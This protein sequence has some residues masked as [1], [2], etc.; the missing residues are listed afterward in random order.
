MSKTD[1]Y[2]A[3]LTVCI[4]DLY[5]AEVMLA[6][7][8]PDVARHANDPELAGLLERVQHEANVA[9]AALA[10][11]GRHKGGAENLWMKGICKDAVRDTGSIVLGPL[12]DA[13]IVGAIRKAKAAQIVSYDTAIAVAAVLGKKDIQANL[14]DIRGRAVA[15]DE[16]LSAHLPAAQPGSDAL[17]KSAQTSS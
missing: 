9:G 1:S 4:E 8:L 2:D 11:T 6:D 12:L 13:A 5:A 15:A 7:T 17:G 16:R 3:L 14:Q 10:E